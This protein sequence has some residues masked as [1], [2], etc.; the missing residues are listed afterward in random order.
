LKLAQRDEVALPTRT[1]LSFMFDIKQA[2]NIDDQTMLYMAQNGLAQLEG[3][4]KERIEVLKEDLFSEK[5]LD[6]YRGRQTK[7]ELEEVTD[8]LTLAIKLMAPHLMEPPVHKLLEFLIRIYEVHI[9]LK[10]LLL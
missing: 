8:K 4:L 3:D 2:A 1:R 6:F 7:E 5:S 9:H 10:H